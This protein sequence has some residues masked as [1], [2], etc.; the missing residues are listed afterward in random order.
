LD[1]VEIKTGNNPLGSGKIAQTFV[2]NIQPMDRGIINQVKFEQPKSSSVAVDNNLK[3]T[4]VASLSDQ[5]G[6]LR[7]SGTAKPG[8]LVTL[9]LYSQMPLVMSVQ[10]DNNGNWV[11]Q[12]DKPLVD[13]KHEI[14]VAINNDEG[15]IVSNSNPLSFFVKEAKAVTMDQYI[16][17]DLPIVTAPDI[18]NRMLVFYIVG[19]S[20]L[21]IS[22]LMLFFM[23]KKFLY[24]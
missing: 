20:A 4:Q 15:R 10:A 3:A 9:Y 6:K 7:F 23:I 14:Y 2:D 24:R 1:L 19:G 18:A 17:E 16:A 11:Y 21:V 12:L 22:V 13:G 8:Q 5:K